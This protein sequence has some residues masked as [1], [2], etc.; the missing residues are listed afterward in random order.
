MGSL[1]VLQLNSDTRD[2]YQVQPL[3]AYQFPELGGLEIRREYPLYLEFQPYTD[4]PIQRDF[5]CKERGPTLSLQC[6]L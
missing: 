1:A 4:P 3:A 5:Y 2:F 6:Q